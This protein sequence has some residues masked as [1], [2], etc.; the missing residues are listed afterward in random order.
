MLLKVVSHYD[1]SVLSMSVMS[2]QKKV[3][4]GGWCEL[5]P[6]SGIYRLIIVTQLFM[7]YFILVWPTSWTPVVGGLIVCE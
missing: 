5:Y 7:Y 3:L 6:V 4:V 2:F 1:F